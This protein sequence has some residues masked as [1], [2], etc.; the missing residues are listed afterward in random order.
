[1]GLVAILRL[2]NLVILLEAMVE[3]LL[4]TLNRRQVT[5]Q[6]IITGQML[7][8]ILVRL[9]PISRHRTVLV[10]LKIILQV[11]VA[12]R[13]T[14]RNPITTAVEDNTAQ[15]RIIPWRRV[16]IRVN[17]LVIH[18]NLIRRPFIRLEVV[19]VHHV[20][21]LRPKRTILMPCLRRRRL[22]QHPVDII[23]RVLQRTVVRIV[24]R[25]ARRH[26]RN[27]TIHFWR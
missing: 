24:R 21:R 20:V 3:H 16:P 1:M 22:L 5:H 25:R 11:V 9:I 17:R 14:N 4:P 18:R 23:R 6:A 26:R 7:V 27:R 2:V 10:L 19:L 8:T 12:T 13:S 15:I